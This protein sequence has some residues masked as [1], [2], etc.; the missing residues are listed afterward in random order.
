MKKLILTTFIISFCVSSIFAQESQNVDLQP[1]NIN[2]GTERFVLFIEEE[3]N[4]KQFISFLERNTKVGEELIQ[5]SQKYYNPDGSVN[6][7]S[8]VVHKKDLSPRYY[9][10]EVQ[11]NEITEEYVFSEHRI[12]GKKEEDKGSEIIDEDFG[13]KDVYNSVIENEILN[14]LN[15]DALR[16]QTLATYNP[17]KGKAEITYKK[18]GEEELM[19][20]GRKINTLKIELTG[21]GLPATYWLSKSTNEVLLLRADFP[22]GSSFWKRKVI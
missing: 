13:Y 11:S 9:F 2:S 15:F 4:V 10:A 20:G 22:N 14:A 7:D 8:S 19:L 18:I 16:V 6:F 1:E 3:G 17:G 21:G 5:V 12:E